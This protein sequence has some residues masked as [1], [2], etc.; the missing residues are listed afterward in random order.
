MQNHFYVVIAILIATSTFAQDYPNTSQKTSQ[1][2][3]HTLKQNNLLK[4]LSN[5]YIPI[6]TFNLDLRYAIKFNQFEG[7]R[8]GL[9]GV[10]NKKFSQSYRLNRNITFKTLEKLY[11]ESGFKL[12]KLFLGLGLSFAYR[13][14]RYH[15]SAFDD[16]I[17]LNLHL[18]YHYN[19]THSIKSITH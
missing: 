15:R 13:Y 8:T 16:N 19:T 7:F 18:T 4:N 5:G 10:T 14:D 2:K 3:K 6:G 17:A 9:G 12:N 11:S 1:T